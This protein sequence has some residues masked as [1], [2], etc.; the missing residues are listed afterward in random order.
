[1]WIDRDGGYDLRMFVVCMVVQGGA[2]D[3]VVVSGFLLNNVEGCLWA[4]VR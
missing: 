4:N 3:V 1:M 2:V